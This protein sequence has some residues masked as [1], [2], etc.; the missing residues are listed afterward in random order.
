M[1][2]KVGT[3]IQGGAGTVGSPAT[4]GRPGDSIWVAVVA[5]LPL[6]FLTAS[7]I[8]ERVVAGP[9][10]RVGKVL[11]LSNFVGVTSQLA[12]AMFTVAS[13]IGAVALWRRNVRTGRW[14]AKV[15][16]TAAVLAYFLAVVGVLSTAAGPDP[17]QYEWKPLYSMP[18]AL[19]AVAPQLLTGI[20]NVYILVRLSR[21]ST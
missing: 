16:S 21:R 17:A 9:Y 20:A 11:A 15:G 6:L 10:T 2:A 1:I 18:A 14:F 8:A 5:L 13:L 4:E 3:D 19:L 7:V 12:L